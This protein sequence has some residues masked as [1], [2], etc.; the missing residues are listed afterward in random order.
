MT[1]LYDL[2]KE[3]EDFII[4]RRLA[5]LACSAA[6]ADDEH[7]ED[8]IREVAKVGRWDRY[9]KPRAESEAELAANA[10]ELINEDRRDE[11]ITRHEKARVAALQEQCETMRE[12]L[13]QILVDDPERS[14][15]IAKLALTLADVNGKLASITEGSPEIL[16]Y[17][18]ALEEAVTYAGD[19]EVC[20]WGDQP[21]DAL[22]W[23]AR[24]REV[25][26]TALSQATAPGGNREPS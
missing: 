7:T 20:L 19:A 22:M 16:S 26:V 24:I 9:M 2:S 21:D 8:A 25:V 5:S 13:E 10:Q 3:E 6:F 23:L 1:K 4:G 11:V 15:E 14:T 17:R 12:A 18:E